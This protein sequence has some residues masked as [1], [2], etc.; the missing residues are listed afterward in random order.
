M[1]SFDPNQQDSKDEASGESEYSKDSGFTEFASSE[2]KNQIRIVL[3]GS[4]GSGKSATGNTILNDTC[5]E[6]KLSFSSITS[7]CRSKK[8][9]IFGKDVQVVDTP[10]LFDTRGISEKTTKKEIVKCIYMTSPGPHCFLLVMDPSRFTKEHKDGVDCLFEFFGNNVFRY[11]IILFT[12]K[13]EIDRTYDRLEDLIAT[14]PSEFSEIIKKC[15][16]RCIAFNNNAPSHVRSSQVQDLLNMIDRIVQDNDGYYTNAM[17]IQA[18]QKMIR[19][20]MEIKKKR[21]EKMER[22]LEELRFQ[23]ETM[24]IDSEMKERMFRELREKNL[25]LRS[26]REEA[27]R[28]IEKDATSIISLLTSAFTLGK[29]I[30]DFVD[31]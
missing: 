16:N 28:D 31:G 5:F 1:A 18:E 21:E 12:K 26:T 25:N 9:K 23:M 20:E 2:G 29:L 30:V 3:V 7:S 6:S 27:V 15:K 10:G 13:D 11:F 8:K 14:V 17:Y 22:E 24:K 4:T 19:R